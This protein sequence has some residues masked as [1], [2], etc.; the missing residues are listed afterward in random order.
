MRFKNLILFAFLILLLF[1]G[2]CLRAQCFKENTAVA[3]GEYLAYDVSYNL[4]P[5]WSKIALVTMVTS[6]DVLG[7]KEVLHMKL[8]GKTYP[9]YDH[10]FK[11]R[12]SYESWINPK[13]FEPAKFLQYTVHN[14]NTILLS[15]FF[16]PASSTY[17]FTYKLNSNP[18]EKG[19]Y[20]VDKCINDMVSAAYFPRTLDLDK[21][22]PGTVITVP[23]VFYNNPVSV[24]MVAAGKGIIEAGDGKKYICSKFTIKTTNKIYLVK[25]GSDVVVW[26]TADKNKVPVLIE[27]EL[28]IGSVK[29]YLKEAKGLRNPSTSLQTKL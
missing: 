27:A 2:E 22:L 16:F 11:I 15:Q 23:L 5:A 9:M 24:Q 10:L 28:I 4:G 14:K 13:T 17:T 1:P 3:P 19:Q 18:V 20:Q 26:L 7:G 25:E 29:F 21:I 12:D 6:T 8:N